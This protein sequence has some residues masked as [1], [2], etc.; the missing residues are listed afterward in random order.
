MVN[1]DKVPLICCRVQMRYFCS[2]VDH[3]LYC[4]DGLT[5]SQKETEGR[6]HV[7]PCKAQIMRQKILPAHGR[8]SALA[9]TAVWVGAPHRLIFFINSTDFFWW[10]VLFFRWTSVDAPQRRR[11]W[12]WTQATSRSTNSSSS[13]SSTPPGEGLFSLTLLRITV[14]REFGAQTFKF[15]VF[16]NHNIPRLFS[17][18]RNILSFGLNYV[19]ISNCLLASLKLPCLHLFQRSFLW[20]LVQTENKN[21]SLSLIQTEIVATGVA[22]CWQ[23][24]N[25]PLIFDYPQVWTLQADSSRGNSWEW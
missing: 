24:E 6:G 1:G 11:C 23:T 10:T 15:F 8:L 25:I 7:F 4:G 14:P 20:C 16:H 12:R 3:S 2:L 19:F 17:R 5:K 22:W 9:S 13:S 18:T 21:H